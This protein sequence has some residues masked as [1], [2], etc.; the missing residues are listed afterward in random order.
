MLTPLSLFLSVATLLMIIAYPSSRVF[1][2][3]RSV[4]Q[5]FN[6]SIVPLITR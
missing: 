4:V 1:I 2:F 6:R 5:S 3:I